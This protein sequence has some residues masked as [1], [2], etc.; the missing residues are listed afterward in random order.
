MHGRIAERPDDFVLAQSKRL[1]DGRCRAEHSARRRDVP[2]ALIVLR[3]HRVADPALRFDTEHE[4]EQQRFTVHR[5]HLR[6]R[7]ERGGDGRGR[8]ND[9]RNMRV[10][11][12]VHVRAHCVER[13]GV[14]HVHAFAA[15][16]DAH[17]IVG[18]E[19]AVDGHRLTERRIVRARER[20]REV[21]DERAFRFVAHD[22][23]QVGPLRLRDETRER[24][25]HRAAAGCVRVDGISLQASLLLSASSRP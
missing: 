17:V 9:G 20:N 2:A 10:V 19:T 4:C 14:Q 13:G 24:A 1:R 23:G 6:Q 3:R 15:A 11:E 12:V 21:I 16:Y 8:V 5:L 7:E 22:H 18:T 25:G